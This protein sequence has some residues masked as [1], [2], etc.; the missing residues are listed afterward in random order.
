[1]HYWFTKTRIQWLSP[2]FIYLFYILLSPT[3]F[4]FMGP[5]GIKGEEG[6]KGQKGETGIP[7]VSPGPKG[8]KGRMGATGFPGPQASCKWIQSFNQTGSRRCF[9]FV[10][11]S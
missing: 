10:S 9:Q 5:F 3:V 7:A 6:E 8:S 1:M 11:F 2:L 4:D